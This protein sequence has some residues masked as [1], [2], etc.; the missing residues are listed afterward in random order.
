ME[1]KKS[2]SA[3]GGLKRTAVPPSANPA[4][5]DQSAATEPQPQPLPAALVPAAAPA[6]QPAMQAIAPQL[7]PAVQP[8]H[9]SPAGEQEKA[10]SEDRGAAVPGNLT[11][12]GSKVLIQALEAHKER[13]KLSFPNVLF[14]AIDATIDVLPGLLESKRVAV[15]KAN[16]FGRPQTVQVIEED[17]SE[18]HSKAMRIGGQHMD[19]LNHL[20]NEYAGGNRNRL[21]VTALS[22]YL[23]DEIEQITKGQSK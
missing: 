5:S 6:S 18:K 12:R 11:I 15:P 22:E 4:G 14:N 8:A 23:K 21:I 10:S 17:A 9:S 3:L 13:T 16:L 20:A 19:V 7:N 1:S 2:L